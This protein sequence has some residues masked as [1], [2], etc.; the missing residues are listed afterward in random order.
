M[1]KAK[2]PPVACV[3]HSMTCPATT[4]P[5][6]ASKSVAR[7]A[8]VRGGRADDQRGVGDPAGDHDVRARVQAL[9]DAPA[10]EVGVG[11]QRALEA[12]LLRGR[13]SPSTW[14]TFTA[15]PVRRAS[16]RIASARPA[17]LSPPALVTILTPLV[18]GEAEAVLE[19]AQERPGVA[20]A[21]VLHPVAAEDEHGQLGEV[22]AGE[23]VE[24][25]AGE[26][27]LH[28]GEPVAV[29]PGRVADADHLPAPRLAPFPGRARRTPARC[30][31]RRRRPRRWRRSAVSARLTPLGGEQA[32][33]QRRPGDPLRRVG[34]A[35]RPDLAVRPGQ[36]DAERLGR[37]GQLPDQVG[38]VAGAD[39][40]VRDVPDPGGRLAAHAERVGDVLA[41]APR[42]P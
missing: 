21:G 34:R 16:S 24:L 11:G 18:G 9:D 17:G 41:R 39:A 1:K 13:S 30:R 22:V 8:E 19:L 33:V 7:P 15:T 32:E 35:P 42:S 26:H 6:S 12:Q 28:G 29:E 3:P 31:A 25:A 20:A 40:D 23:D 38:E 36:L 27:L 37:R 2:L 10:A 4:A 14:A 5:A